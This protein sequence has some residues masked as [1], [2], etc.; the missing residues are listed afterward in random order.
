MRIVTEKATALHFLVRNK[1]II[2]PDLGNKVVISHVLC[3]VLCV[4][5]DGCT[6]IN[7]WAEEDVFVCQ[8]SKR[9]GTCMEK[10]EVYDE[11]GI[12]MF[13]AKHN[14]GRYRMGPRFTVIPP[15]ILARTS[16]TCFN[17]IL[18]G[19]LITS[20]MFHGSLVTPYDIIIHKYHWE[21][22]T[23]RLTYKWKIS[24]LGELHIM[25]FQSDE[26]PTVTLMLR[27]GKFELY[28]FKKGEVVGRIL[29][30]NFC[31]VTPTLLTYSKIMYKCGRKFWVYDYE[32]AITTNSM[33]GKK[34]LLMH[35]RNKRNI[36]PHLKNGRI[37]S[38]F[39]FLETDFTWLYQVIPK[40]YS[41]T[42]HHI[43]SNYRI[44]T[45]HK[46]NF[47]WQRLFSSL[48]DYK[49]SLLIFVFHGFV[50]TDGFEVK[51]VP[52]QAI[53]PKV[54][55]KTPVVTLRIRLNLKV[56]RGA[57]TNMRIDQHGNVLQLIPAKILHKGQ[58]VKGHRVIHFYYPI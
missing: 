20:V 23:M 8:R 5:M 11:N 24:T 58:K 51:C 56:R 42:L 38:A 26:Y 13:Q 9:K 32:I 22:Y 34:E 1:V 46:L 55:C 4:M 49:S 3:A 18:S 6:V 31:S 44:F 30:P 19:Y 37:K 57:S 29:L 28:D 12:R 27:A 41:I 47:K 14:L 52:K 43:W 2:Q 17:Q 33:S 39:F 54:V 35:L 16:D 53:S 50:T 10:G 40:H 15:I 48:H 7:L 25:D 36:K 45:A 21:D